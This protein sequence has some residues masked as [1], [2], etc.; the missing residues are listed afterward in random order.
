M[1]DDNIQVKPYVHVGRESNCLS[2]TSLRPV[3]TPYCDK[4]IDDIDSDN[5]TYSD[6]YAASSYSKE[7][8]TNSSFG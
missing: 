7:S 1:V 4:L 8:P 5:G 6:D 3:D 2:S